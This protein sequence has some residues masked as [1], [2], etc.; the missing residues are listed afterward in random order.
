MIGIRRQMLIAALQ[1][2]S[3]RDAIVAWS[4]YDSS[5]APGTSPGSHEQPPYRTAW[6]AVCD[7]WRVVQSSR[8]PDPPPGGEL[9]LGSMVYECIL[10]KEVADVGLP[11]V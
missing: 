5:G 1:G 7:G 10:S 8:L 4:H 3:L 9:R 2:P 6:D 11:N